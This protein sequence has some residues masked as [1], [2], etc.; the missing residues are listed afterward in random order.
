MRNYLAAIFEELCI[1][2]RCIVFSNPIN[3]PLAAIL[4]AIVV[5]KNF[6]DQIVLHFRYNIFF[7]IVNTLIFNQINRKILA[8]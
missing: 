5:F 2:G 1:Y 7:Y 4:Q 3:K 8:T 6:E